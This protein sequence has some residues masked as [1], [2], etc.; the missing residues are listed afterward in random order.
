M[1]RD[2]AFKAVNKYQ[3]VYFHGSGTAQGATRW[4]TQRPDQPDWGF[5]AEVTDDGRWLLIYQSEGT[6]RENRLFLKDLGD[7][8][9]KIEPFLDKFDA[10]YNVVGN[11][12]ATF[13]VV[14][15]KDAP[16]YRVVAIDEGQG[17]SRAR[18][19]RSSPK[20]PNRDVLPR[21]PSSPIAS[22]RSGAS[23][24]HEKLSS[25]LSTGSRRARSPCPRS[26][27]SAG[28]TG[29][30]QGHRTRSTPSPPSTI[31]TTSFRYD[32]A[33]KAS[34]V[35]KQ[36][37]VDFDPNAFETRQVFYPSKDGTKIPMFII[38]KKGSSAE[39]LEP[40]LCSTA[41]AASTFR[42]TPAFS[43][44]DIAWME[45]GGV[46]AVRQPARRRRVWQAV[47]RRRPAQEQAERVRRLHRRG[48]SG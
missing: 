37:K 24:A 39:R 33:T 3:K 7:P 10:S 29:Q 5:G 40:D 26:G 2:D 1:S 18:G 21:S 20:A 28:I 46:Y 35:F 32:F 8:N 41:T 4:S 25:S 38:H 15:D 44:R 16:R 12:G 11:D 42:S 22:S 31:H 14:T 6:N 27:P 45:M 34:T 13:Y 17:R 43:R 9:G 36:P 19:R 48:A 47:A 23:D 30:A